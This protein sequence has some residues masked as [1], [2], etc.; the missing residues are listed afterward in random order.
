[1]FPAEL[2][3]VLLNLLTNAIKA[4]GQ[5]GKIF[6]SAKTRDDGT[7]LFKLENTGA[8]VD[9][10]ADPERWFRPFETTTTD[11]DPL[12][13]QGMGFGLPIT[14]DIL[15]EYGASIRFVAPRKGYAAAIT[16]EFPE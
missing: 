5:G 14:R 11:I 2:T 16:I 7:L 8:T 12:L 9:L 4:A 1:M 15:D 13:G 6:A 10:E 3:A